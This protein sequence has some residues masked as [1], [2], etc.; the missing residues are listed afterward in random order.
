[1]DEE[2]KEDI[3]LMKL[4]NGESSESENENSEINESNDLA[5]YIVKK[6]M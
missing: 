1:M 2:N 5:T 4:K 3:N 6:S